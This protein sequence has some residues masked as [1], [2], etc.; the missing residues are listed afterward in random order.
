MR[1][2]STPCRFVPPTRVPAYRL[3]AS[4]VLD[5]QHLQKSFGTVH[6]VPDVSLSVG[7]GQIVGLL[8]PNGA[9]KTTTV[10]MIAG[11]LAP[12]RGEVR[13][14]GRR[15]TGDADPGK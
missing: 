1:S 13:V 5:V 4:V 6:A 8:G 2:A 7:R 15:L 14:D 9:G 11:L 12:D 3:P 10:S